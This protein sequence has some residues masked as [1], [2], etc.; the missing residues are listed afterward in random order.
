MHK[1]LEKKEDA[2]AYDAA[3]KLKTV[4]LAIKEGNKASPHTLGRIN[5]GETLEMPE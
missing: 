2:A 4:N 5:H 1:N 3:F